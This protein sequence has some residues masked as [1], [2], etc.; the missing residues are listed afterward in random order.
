M[1]SAK[2]V[3][4]IEYSYNETNTRIGPELAEKLPKAIGIIVMENMQE[5][6]RDRLK[7]YALR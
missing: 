6:L 7:R 5:R 4:I 2:V 1:S 3:L